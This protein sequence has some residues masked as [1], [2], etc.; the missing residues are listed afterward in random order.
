MTISGLS[1]NFNLLGR[2][3]CWRIWIEDDKVFLAQAYGKQYI[4]KFKY[5]DAHT[6]GFSMNSSLDNIKLDSKYWLLSVTTNDPWHGP[7]T[8]CLSQLWIKKNVVQSIGF[9]I[10][11]Q[12]HKR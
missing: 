3:I 6:L 9:D 2:S 11:R 8:D 4:I 10:F 7:G 5:Y 1:E 12:Q